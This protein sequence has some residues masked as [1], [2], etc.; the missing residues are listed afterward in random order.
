MTEL[1]IRAGEELERK[2][3]RYAR[4]RLEPTA[5]QAKRARATVMEAAWRQRLAAPS[6]LRP[7]APVAAAAATVIS[8]RRGLFAGWGA[9]R[10]GTSLAAAALAGLVVGSTAFAASRAGA[11]LYDVRLAL[12]EL[13]LPADGP[14]RLEAELALAQGRLAEIVDGVARDDSGA[15]SAA[16]RGYLASLDD[17]DAST[18]GPADRA[19]DAITKH[20]KVLLAVL[21]TAPEDA[22]KGLEQA[23]ASSSKAI[24]VLAAAGTGRPLDDGTGNGVTPGSGNG[25]GTGTNGTN[26]TNGAGGANGQGGSHGNPNAGNGGANG[27]GGKPDQPARPAKTPQPAKTS[28]PEEDPTKVAKSPNPGGAK[29]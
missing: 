5:A 6:A 12:E 10:L 15:V 21:A 9:R 8:P 22:V 3:E 28:A 14:A 4:L 2:M 7:E 29:P 18:G 19:L 1:E 17:L 27:Q 24:E 23:I 13:S 20:N 25:A 11:P 26:G 16:V